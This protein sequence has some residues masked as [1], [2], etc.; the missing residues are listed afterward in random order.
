MGVP[1]PALYRYAANRDYEK[2][3]LR[4]QSHRVDI[5]WTDRYGSTALHLLCQDRSM[6]NPASLLR[7]V[8]AILQQAPEV[9]AWANAATWSPLHF[10]AEKRLV[11][12][13]DLM[14]QLL[15]ACPQAVSLRTK[16]GFKSK[17]PFHIAC[18]AD[19]SYRVLKAMLSIDPRLAVQP[20]VP[21]EEQ[22]CS[23]ATFE[24]P[25]QLLWRHEP[26]T[27]ETFG[28][29]ALLLQAAYCGTVNRQRRGFCLIN[30]VCTVRCPTDY[31]AQ[32]LQQSAVDRPDAR[33]L[34]PL[35]YAV[36]QARR[37]P[38]HYTHFIIQ[39][40]LRKAPETAAVPDKHGRLPLHVAVG[41]VGLTWHKG[42]VRELSY[43]YTA[44]L[45]C[46][47]PRTGLVPALQSAVR[48]T[49]SK[50]HLSTTLELL[51]MAP[52]VCQ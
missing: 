20:F 2:I 28:K 34:L 24:N 5:Y 22:H 9:V 25:L 33:G 39:H 15:D 26:R 37:T 49:E 43:T 1:S 6:E 42:G 46:P 44:A 4:V 51:L 17:T 16:S 18:E 12:S 47:D 23:Y 31:A 3:P 50:L 10:A 7:A 40:L 29:M 48:A 27:V 14:L 8:D 11:A 19:A 52:D 38:P 30:A 21:Q 32:I 35:H 13:A 36:A 41:D 45:R